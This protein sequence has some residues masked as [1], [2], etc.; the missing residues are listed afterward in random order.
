MRSKIGVLMWH[1]GD[2]V[3]GIDSDSDTIDAFDEREEEFLEQVARVINPLVA[4]QNQSR[5]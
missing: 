1:A 2:R 4:E 3:G 5:G